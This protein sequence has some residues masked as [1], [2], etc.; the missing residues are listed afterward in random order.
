MFRIF[1]APLFQDE[2]TQ[3]EEQKMQYLAGKV[4]KEKQRDMSNFLNNE[5]VK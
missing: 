3:T 1:V 2:P 4:E 5:I